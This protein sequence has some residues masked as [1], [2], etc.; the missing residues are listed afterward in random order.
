MHEETMSFLG[1]AVKARFDAAPLADLFATL[2]GKWEEPGEHTIE[3]EFTTAPSP[4]DSWLEAKGI[5]YNSMEGG[6][7]YVRNHQAAGSIDFIRGQ[8]RLSLAQDEAREAIGF[9]M[10]SVFSTFAAMHGRPFIHASGVVKQGRACLFA[11]HSGAGKSTIAAMLARLEG[12]EILHDDTVFLTEDQGVVMA[13]ASP[14]L[15]QEGFASHKPARYPVEAIYL[16]HQSLVPALGEVVTPA[17]AMAALFTAPLDSAIGPGTPSYAAYLASA[18]P[19]YRRLLVQAPCRN[20]AFSLSA[21]PKSI[22]P[23]TNE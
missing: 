19:R 23:A 1:L 4:N 5:R 16:L 7:L 10:R 12:G 2:Y 11:G 20:L 17:L 9:V 22:F 14:Y 6:T 18:M 15:G 8:G 13:E 21:L 3:M